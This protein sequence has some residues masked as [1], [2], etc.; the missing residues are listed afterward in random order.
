METRIDGVKWC[1]VGSHESQ[2]WNT[3]AK[4]TPGP[5]RACFEE[6]PRSRTGEYSSWT[7]STCSLC[8]L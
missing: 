1:A 6:M 3:G 5:N 7:D 2:P 8:G 4:A